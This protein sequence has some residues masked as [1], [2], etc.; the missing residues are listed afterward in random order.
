MTENVQE[1]VDV[2]TEENSLSLKWSDKINDKVTVNY[3]VDTKGSKYVGLEHFQLK[4]SEVD[5][6]L[7][8]QQTFETIVENSK[9]WF[10]LTKV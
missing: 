7:F 2:L 8:T 5:E 6:V 3:Y 10:G 9:V 1:S 4:D